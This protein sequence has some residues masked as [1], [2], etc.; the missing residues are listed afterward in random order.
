MKIRGCPTDNSKKSRFSLSAVPLS[1]GSTLGSLV[2]QRAFQPRLDQSI[3]AVNL[4]MYGLVIS[5]PRRSNRCLTSWETLVN[6]GQWTRPSRDGRASPASAFAPM[7]LLRANNAAVL[8]LSLALSFASPYLHLCICISTF[9][10]ERKG[11]AGGG[12]FG[13]ARR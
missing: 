6:F 11:S 4:S 10:F 7:E 13:S 12:G 8:L 9:A 5:F 1:K 3:F 2:S